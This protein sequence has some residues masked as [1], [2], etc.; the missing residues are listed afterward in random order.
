MKRFPRQQLFPCIRVHLHKLPNIFFLTQNTRHRYMPALTS[1]NM[2]IRDQSGALPL[3]RI[4]SIS[5]LSVTECR[6]CYDTDIPRYRHIIVVHP[7]C[8][9][10]SIATINRYYNRPKVQGED[11]C[12]SMGQALGNFRAGKYSEREGGGRG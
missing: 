7:T 10:D 8:M 6:K 1:R 9:H 4:I 12:I 2:H 3:P 5:E 11:T